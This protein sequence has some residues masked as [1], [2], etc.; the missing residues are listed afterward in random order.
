MQHANQE[1]VKGLPPVSPPSGKHIVQLFVVP[2]MI[3]AVALGIVWIF[4]RLFGG[5]RTP[6][7][8]LKDLSSPNAEIRWRA[9]SDLADKLPRDKD[10]AT[11]PRFN[12]ALAVL[13]QRFLQDSDQSAL[14]PVASRPNFNP[15]N[16]HE[17][18]E[19]EKYILFLTN[20]L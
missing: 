6:E 2:A 15:D 11:D 20:C 16:W 18:P 1:P 19:Q 3:V 7:Q 17:L 5:T 8:F 10:L 13:L 14:S 9:A 12:L 4:D